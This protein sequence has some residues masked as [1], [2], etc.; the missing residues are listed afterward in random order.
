MLIFPSLTWCSITVF[1]FFKTFIFEIM[2]LVYPYDW[3]KKSILSRKQ[4]SFT[5]NE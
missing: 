1:L 3:E 5:F 4:H 2:C